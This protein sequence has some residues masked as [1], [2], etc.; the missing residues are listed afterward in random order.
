MACTNNNITGTNACPERVCIQANRVFDACISQF[1]EESIT[2]P[3]S[4]PTPPVTFVSADSTGQCIISNVVITPQT[5]STC[6]RIQYTV[7]VPMTVVA[8]DGG[9]NTILGTT[10]VTF[11]RDILL[12]VPK[13]SIIPAEVECT[14]N[15]VGLRGTFSDSTLTFTCCV[16]LITKIV[17][18]VEL[19]IYT[20]G[21]P[22]LP[23][24]Q[25]YAED[26]CAGVFNVPL[27]PRG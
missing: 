5:G 6:S 20:N 12:K 25:E 14:S 2:V 7:T 26:L 24:C 10:A 1:T 3:V 9:G 8:L 13:Q 11:N 18:P 21:Y 22:A 23:N 17:A 4:F 16:T 19:L 27:Y 15:I